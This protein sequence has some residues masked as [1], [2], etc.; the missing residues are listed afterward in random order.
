M[1]AGT[2]AEAETFEEVKAR[3]DEIVERVSDEGLPLEEALGL[4]E[5]AVALGLQASRIM[6]EGIAERDAAQLGEAGASAPAAAEGEG[7]SA[8]AE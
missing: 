2:A 5:E 1:G 6:E 4:Y 7:A 3:L 8:S